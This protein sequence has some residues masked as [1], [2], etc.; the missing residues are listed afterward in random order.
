M[1]FVCSQ[2]HRSVCVRLHACFFKKCLIKRGRHIAQGSADK[3]S[4]PLSPLLLWV[5]KIN[6]ENRLKSS[7][8]LYWRLVVAFTSYLWLRRHE[9]LFDELISS[10]F[11]WN[12]SNNT[13]PITA[14]LYWQSSVGHLLTTRQLQLLFFHWLAMKSVSCLCVLPKCVNTCWKRWIEKWE[15]LK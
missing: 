9:K 12:L 13:L 6:D 11:V 4:K 10:I 1:R 7:W 15:S 3:F 2:D 14:R 8:I 5:G